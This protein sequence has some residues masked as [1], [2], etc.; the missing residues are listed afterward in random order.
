MKF[1][2]GFPAP[3][4][5]PVRIS[6]GLGIQGP[7]R[8]RKSPDGLRTEDLGRGSLS[9]TSL[10]VTVSMPR[11][12]LVSP[13]Y[14]PL[15]LWNLFTLSPATGLWAVGFPIPSSQMRGSRATSLPLMAWISEYPC[16]GEMQNRTTMATIS[17]KSSWRAMRISVHRC[18]LREPHYVRLVEQC[19]SLPCLC[20]DRDPD[21]ALTAFTQG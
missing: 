16:P 21:A 1:R 15:P 7:I 3:G 12:L 6:A 17:A 10:A 2:F 20:I 5:V 19:L 8:Q 9:Q 4:F 14:R 11:C 18:S 13:F